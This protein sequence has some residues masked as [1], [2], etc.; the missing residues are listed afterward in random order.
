MTQKKNL[1]RGLLAFG[2]IL[3]VFNLLAFLI[4]FRHTAPFWVGYVF[5][6]IAIFA[7]PLILYVAFRGAEAARSKFY[8][9]PIARIGVIFAAAQLILSFAAMALAFIPGFPAWPIILVSVLLLGAAALGVIAA[10]DTKAEIERQDTKLKK[11]VRSMRALQS[12]GRGLVSQCEDKALGAELGKLSDE[13]RFSD[14]VSSEATA[15]SEAELASLLDEL[16][17][18]ILE[19]DATGASGLCKKAR[20]VLAERNR[21]CKLNK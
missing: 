4:P 1:I 10:E 14:P 16:Q 9:V 11:D 13:L 15:D 18:A 3:V 8:G 19:S 20:A 5:G 2:V 6:M 17:R 7:L 21:I 12:M